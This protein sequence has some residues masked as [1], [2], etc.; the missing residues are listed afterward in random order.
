MLDGRPSD[1]LRAEIVTPDPSVPFDDPGR[2]AA[3]FLKRKS[4]LEPYSPEP[5]SL[6]EMPR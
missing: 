2:F 6:A 3:A 4:E 1:I 5:I